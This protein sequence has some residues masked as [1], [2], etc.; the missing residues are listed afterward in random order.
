MMKDRAAFVSHLR[1]TIDKATAAANL[2]RDIV[3]ADAEDGAHRIYLLLDAAATLNVYG[4]CLDALTNPD[5]KA[6]LET[7]HEYAVG[8]VL[9]NA[10]SW[11][12]GLYEQK[13]ANTWA[14]LV[15]DLKWRT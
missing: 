1:T 8:R 11:P 6:T 4:Q 10:K 2:F 15:D 13:I 14:Q 9:S 5:S 3:T 12:N 7:I